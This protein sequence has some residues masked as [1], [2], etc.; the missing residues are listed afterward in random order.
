MKR[1]EIYLVN[2]GKKYNSEF[3]KI[4]PALIIQNDVANRNIDKVQFKGVTVIPLSTNIFGGDLRVIVE[5]RENL[6]KR[7][8]ICINELCTLDIS[9]IELDNIL[10]LLNN[11]ELKEVDIKLSRHL[12][13]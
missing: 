3:G 8:E 2:F 12:G 1:G 6:K 7:S 5:K 9:R 11:Q 10:T 4:R 13:L